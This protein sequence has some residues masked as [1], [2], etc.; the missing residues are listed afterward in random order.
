M[1]PPM[2]ERSYDKNE[3]WAAHGLP[4]VTVGSTVDRSCPLLMLTHYNTCKWAV[5]WAV[6]PNNF[7][8]HIIISGNG[9]PMGS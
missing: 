5:Q 9:L 4:N 1:W 7:Q 8:T 6:L 2:N 3:K